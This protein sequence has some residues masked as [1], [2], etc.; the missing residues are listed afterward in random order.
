MYCLTPKIYALAYMHYNPLTNYSPNL[1]H[2]PSLIYQS[3]HSDLNNSYH[4]QESCIQDTWISSQ[5]IMQWY[6]LY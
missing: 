2:Y 4:I 1:L 5:I 3:L 6:G